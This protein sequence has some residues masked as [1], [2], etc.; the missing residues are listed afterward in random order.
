MVPWQPALE[1]QIGK[2][3]ANV[4]RCDR[5]NWRFGPEPGGPAISWTMCPILL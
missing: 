5:G 3:V 1:R 4:V 2:Q